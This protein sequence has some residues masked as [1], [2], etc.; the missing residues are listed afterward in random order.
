MVPLWKAL[1]LM[2]THYLMHQHQPPTPIYSPPEPSLS[3]D[4]Q[5]AGRVVA[6]DVAFLVEN[7]RGGL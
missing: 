4:C 6:T 3:S 2:E 7:L 1:H 5:E